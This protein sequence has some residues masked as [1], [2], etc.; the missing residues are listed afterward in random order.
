MK[1]GD[2]L[3]ANYG[4]INRMNLAN[5]SIQQSEKRLS[6]GKR[7]NSGADDPVGIVRINRLNSQIRGN[8]VAQRN[9]QDA[10]S[11]SQTADSALSSVNDMAQRIRELSVQYNNATL[12]DDDKSSIKAE[13]QALT[14]EMS[15]TLT[16]TSFGG[17]KNIFDKSSYTIQT[18]ANQDDTY[19]L[20]LPSL[21]YTTNQ[22]QTTTSVVSKTYS[23]TTSGTNVQMTI[24]S[25]SCDQSFSVV[26]DGV[27]YNGTINFN[28]GKIGKFNLTGTNGSKI[29]G[30][31]DLNTQ[32]TSDN[33][34]GSN[35][36]KITSGSFGTFS[37]TA[38]IS[39]VSQ[40]T[41]TTTSTNSVTN[42]LKNIGDVDIEQVLNTN[43][44][45]TNILKPL[46]TARASIGTS[47]EILEKRSDYQTSK[48]SIDTT[49][50]SNIEDV[51]VAKETL[52]LTK[53]Q[54]LLNSNLSLFSQSLSDDK[55]YILSLLR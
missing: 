33:I 7:V 51:D 31:L 9:I 44:I 21:S 55:N 3:S 40:K 16:S 48:E 10:T 47:Q 49:S 28:G 22:D 24:G 5:K 1:I 30:E 46:N 54:I 19:D 25:G 35:A 4:M 14:K 37:S 11:L 34:S 39:F 36:F 8:Q 6:T 43:F 26:A 12:S 50:L 53:Q 23:A 38:N 17:I 27:T 32:S 29:G 13:A 18:G 52:N 45:D 20:K 42:S 15:K 41:Q 2:L